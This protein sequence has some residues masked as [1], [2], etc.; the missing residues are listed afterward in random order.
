[1]QIGSGRRGPITEKLQKAF[2][3]IVEGR[4]ADKHGWLTPVGV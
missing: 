3:D 2:F 1:M 4:A